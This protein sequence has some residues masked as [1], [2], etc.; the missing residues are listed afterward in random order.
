M[1]SRTFSAV[2]R[3]LRSG[4]VVL[5]LIG[6]FG[7]LSA[8]GGAGGNEADAGLTASPDRSLPGLPGASGSAPSSM[9]GMDMSSPSGP[10]A[11]NAVAP[12]AGNAVAIKNFAFAPAALTVKVG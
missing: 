12:V 3:K 11:G 10:A 7:L 5:A 9:P 4:A 8:C 6:S 2:A 1:Q